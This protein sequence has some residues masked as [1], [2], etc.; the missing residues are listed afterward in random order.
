M[1]LA[2]T[3]AVQALAG[4]PVHDAPIVSDD[5]ALY[6]HLARVEA[7]LRAADVAHLSPN[8]RARRAELI[9]VLHDYRQAGV[10]P[11]NHDG[12]GRTRP[13]HVTGAF[14]DDPHRTPVF[15]D[16]HGTHCAVGYLLAVDGQDALVERIVAGGN[17]RFVH[18]ID[19]PALL[20]WA[21]ASGFSRDELARIQP[22]YDW[23]DEDRDGWTTPDD[24]NDQDPEIHPEADEICGD[25]IDNNCVDG[26][27][28]CPEE[29]VD[30][31]TCGDDA[32]PCEDVTACA[33]LSPIAA[34]PLALVVLPLVR[35]RR[36]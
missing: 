25:G 14:P 19:D 36:R 30:P 2:L 1:L 16:E 10:F 7:D 24:C 15:V 8:Q 13:V 23:E 17:L 29:P 26:D 3:L 32:S 31:E 33:T 35:R 21:H 12:V 20:A 9:E 18:E 11:H 6:A 4:L 22:S 27:A 5:P 28:V 34:W